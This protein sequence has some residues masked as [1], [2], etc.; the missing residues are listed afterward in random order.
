MLYQVTIS[1]PDLSRF[2]ALT[3]LLQNNGF[4]SPVSNS[5][6]VT[7][8]AEVFEGRQGAAIVTAH[9]E[10][11]ARKAKEEKAEAVPALPTTPV[12]IDEE[13][14]K[15]SGVADATG[16]LIKAYGADGRDQVV[17]LLAKFGQ[18]GDTPT[19]RKIPA[20]QWGAYVAEAKRLIVAAPTAG[21]LS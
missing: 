2:A 4:G 13:A 9:V 19:A 10:K 6:S 1:T 3:L 17:K 16:A 12:V 8:P 11:K 21:Q 7:I 5:D 20:T 15:A 18:T 14:Y